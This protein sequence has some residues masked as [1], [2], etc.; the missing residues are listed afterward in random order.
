MKIQFIFIGK[1]L[2]LL[3]LSFE[4]QS[5]NRL[6]VLTSTMNL[7]SITEKI[8]GNKIQLESITR[9]SQDP[10]FLSAKP[11]YMLKVS[12]A[13]LLIFVGM[14][15]E[16]GWL[17]SIVKGARNLQIREGQIGYL[18]ASQFITPLSV[19]KGKVDRFFGDVHPFGNPHFLLDPLRAVQVSKGISQRLSLLDPKNE[20]YYIENQKKFEKSIKEKMKIWSKRIKDSSVTKIVTYHNSFEYFLD[21][22]QL[23]LVGLIEEKSGIPPSAKHV[24]KLIKK[25][26]ASQCS[27]ILMSSFYNNKRIMNIND[28]I[29]VH[30]ETTAIEV[31]ALKKL[32]NYVFV[33]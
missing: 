31:M 16:A 24:L 2:F 20:A 10:H 26:K 5:K 17:S 8:G 6:N 9:G 11:S 7:K 23:N 1:L 3:T 4:V 33:I 14:G 19:P 32:K 28:A 29:P 13:D 18:D 22:F 12:K 15:L 25:M 21:Q 30:I 27:C